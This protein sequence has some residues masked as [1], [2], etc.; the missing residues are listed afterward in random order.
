MIAAGRLYGLIYDGRFADV[1]RPEA[2]GLAE[3]MLDG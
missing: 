3:A 2:I 1:G